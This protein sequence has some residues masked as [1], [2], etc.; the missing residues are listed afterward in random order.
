MISMKRISGIRATLQDREQFKYIL[1][2]LGLQHDQWLENTIL[3]EGKIFDLPEIKIRAA[4]NYAISQ[5]EITSSLLPVLLGGTYAEVIAS[6]LQNSSTSQLGVNLNGSSNNKA[7]IYDTT[8]PSE[9]AEKLLGLMDSNDS[10]LTSWM[11]QQI[12]SQFEVLVNYK[13]KARLDPYILN[14]ADPAQVIESIRFNQFP[15]DSAEA[16]MIRLLA[17]PFNMVQLKIV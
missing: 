12:S 10:N 15:V 16:E 3:S 17:N 4:I 9:A 13:L 2:I 8:I 6:A 5:N 7:R 1:S 11:L 14:H